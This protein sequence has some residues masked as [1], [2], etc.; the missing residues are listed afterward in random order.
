MSIDWDTNLL[1]PVMAVFGGGVN[2]RPRSGA[3]FDIADA[4]FDA[5]YT[6]VAKDPQTG[7]DVTTTSP[8]LGVRSI[9]F[10]TPPKQND[11]VLIKASGILYVVKDVLPDGHGHI[12]LLLNKKA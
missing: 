9:L 5:Q 3:A 1:G 11:S 8:V 10:S 12:R 7:D 2:Y 4:V 6:Y